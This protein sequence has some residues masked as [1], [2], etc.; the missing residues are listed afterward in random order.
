MSPMPR[1]A[2]N[3]A[4]GFFSRPLKSPV[5]AGGAP[6]DGIVLTSPLAERHH[7]KLD[8]DSGGWFVQD[9]K[10]SWNVLVN[11]VPVLKRYLSDGDEISVGEDTV[12][13]H[14]DA[15]A[16]EVLLASSSGALPASLSDLPPIGPWSERLLARRA[17]A[18][19]RLRRRFRAFALAVLTLAFAFLAWAWLEREASPPPP[20]PPFSDRLLSDALRREREGDFPAAISAARAA[21]AAARTPARK[22]EAERLAA[23]CAS[24]LMEKDERAAARLPASPELLR[25]PSSAAARRFL[26]RLVRETARRPFADLSAA[27]AEWRE[28][29]RKVSALLASGDRLAAASL[30]RAFA[31]RRPSAPQ[32]PW[33]K[34][35]ADSLLAAARR[36]A[37]S[38]YSRRGAPPPRTDFDFSSPAAFASWRVEEGRWTRTRS[39]LSLD[40][41][42][43]PPAS[44]ACDSLRYCGV[45]FWMRLCASPPRDGSLS[46]GLSGGDC[47]LLVVL[48]PSSCRLTIEAGGERLELPFDPPPSFPCT[49]ELALAE[50]ALVLQTGR[51]LLRAR[52]PFAWMLEGNPVL[53]ASAPGASVLSLSLGR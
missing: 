5:T 18:L 26:L 52:V 30:L 42:D 35:R 27:S 23:R 6:S 24:A 40:S 36:A 50:G 46:A 10:G 39:G 16:P 41:V 25:F 15:P 1:L 17:F 53:S 22:A 7:F 12:V 51:S 20:S 32:A 2:V 19:R 14:D 4:E 48:S 11:D 47:S 37:L 31:E 43:V 21:L 29:A 38:F 9:L 28:L 33:A 13:F 45:S 44:L 3:T 34:L 49:V 8:L